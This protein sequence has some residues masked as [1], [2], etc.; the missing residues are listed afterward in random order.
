MNSFRSRHFPSSKNPIM[1]VQEYA[2][3]YYAVFMI[4][5]LMAIVLKMF[6]G[7]GSIMGLG[8]GGVL[9]AM[10]FG[11]VAAVVTLR[12]T[13]AQIF[14]VGEH[15]SLISVYD[16][17]FPKQKPAFPLRYANAT[18]TQDTLSFHFNDQIITLV[19]ADWED[20]DLIWEAFQFEEETILDVN[21]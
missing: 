14:F 12:K 4:F 7:N 9:I 13:Y 5:L 15:F 16:I 17:L 18:R 8:I 11:N 19:R 21:N 2:M 10:G 3:Y 1:L 6:A 20:L